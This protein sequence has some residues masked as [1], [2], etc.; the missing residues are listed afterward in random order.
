MLRAKALV[1][2]FSSTL[3]L[4][5]CG[6]LIG[7][8]DYTEVEGSAAGSGGKGGGSGSSG[9]GSSGE[10][11]SAVGGSSGGRGGSSGKGGAGASAGGGGGVSGSTAAGGGQAGETDGEGGTAGT[12]GAAGAR[13][14]GGEAGQGGVEAGSGGAGAGGEGGSQ[15]GASGSGGAPPLT[16]TELTVT[17]IVFRLDDGMEGQQYYYADFAPMAGGPDPDYVS[18]QFFH[19]NGYDGAQ[20]GTFDLG[21]VEDRQ[22]QTCSRCIVVYEDWTQATERIF[23]QESG[24]LYI[25]PSSDQMNGY[26]TAELTDVTL[27]EVTFDDDFVSTPVPGGDCLHIAHAA[28]SVTPEDPAWDGDNCALHWRNDEVCDCGCGQLDPDCSAPTADVCAGCYCQENTDCNPDNN[29]ICDPVA[30]P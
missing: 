3:M 4:A 24:S 23:F 25:P 13:N 18:L 26:L 16:C 10:G 27:I 17:D 1:T 30:P 8:G 9:E 20:R 14:A 22:Y 7:L 12:S 6:Q 15:A 2:L 29:W 19:G 21:S 11:G 5:A 28:F